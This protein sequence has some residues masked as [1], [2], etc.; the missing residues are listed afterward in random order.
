MNTLNKTTIFL[1]FLCSLAAGPV[2]AEE[3]IGYELDATE[4][5][6]DE[7]TDRWFIDINECN[8][9]ISHWV[10]VTEETVVMNQGLQVK[11][12]NYKTIHD[13]TLYIQVNQ[14]TR[15]AVNIFF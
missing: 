7:K 1:I 15:T 6:H 2:W 12:G 9:C 3:I 10:E 4:W 13:Q 5:R 8:G 14:E 11:H